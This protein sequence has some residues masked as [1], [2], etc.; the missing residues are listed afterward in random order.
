MATSIVLTSGSLFCGN[1]IV[2]NVTAEATPTDAVFHRVKLEVK[3]KRNITG[4]AQETFVLSSPVSSSETI[5][6]DISSALRSVAE[7]DTYSPLTADSTLQP[8]VYTLR[9]WDEYMVNGLL[10]EDVGVRSYGSTLYALQGAFT[11]MERLLSSATKSVQK[12]TRK[13]ITGEVC[14]ADEVLVYPAPY[15][16]AASLTGNASTRTS[17]VYALTNLSG[18]QTYHGHTIYVV[19]ASK[20][21]YLFQFVNSLGMM[22]SISVESLAAHEVEKTHEEHIVTAPHAFNKINRAIASKTADRSIIKLST[23]PLTINWLDWFAHEFMEARQMWVRLDGNYIPCS[24]I[25]EEGVELVDHTGNT[26]PAIEF[27]VKLNINGG[28]RNLL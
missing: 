7:K 28:W 12:F 16:T 9:A 1:P 4:E 14:A 18:A 22:E 15:T 13:P 11:D 20:H 25:S 8:L 27:T 5:K 24:I 10:T 19:P 21:R 2:V 3:A 17:K 26:L 6:I 23:G